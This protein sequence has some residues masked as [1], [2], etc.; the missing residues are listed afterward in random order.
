MWV[1]EENDLPTIN[2]A[3][4][5]NKALSCDLR[6]VHPQISECIEKNQKRIVDL[7]LEQ[8]RMVCGHRNCKPPRTNN[9]SELVLIHTSARWADGA[10]LFSELRERLFAWHGLQ[11]TTETAAA[12]AVTM[13]N[14]S[15]C[16]LN[17]TILT[18]FFLN[19]PTVIWCWSD[20]RSDATKSRSGATNAKVGQLRV[21]HLRPPLG[22]N[23]R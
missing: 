14:D 10:L 20:C 9:Q 4:A 22:Q 18:D 6:K 12:A 17:E 11:L 13:S 16:I 8:A 21:G 1:P 7:V 2:H 3:E 15:L 23:L 19:W 5:A